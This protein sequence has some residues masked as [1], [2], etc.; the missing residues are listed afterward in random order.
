M[1]KFI[2]T[3]LIIFLYR[4]P[5]Q[6]ID[7]KILRQKKIKI[8]VISYDALGDFIIS[9]PLLE[10]IKR[11]FPLAKID[12]LCSQRNSDLASKYNWFNKL[13]P[14]QLN[15]DFFDVD[16]WKRIFAI[17][18][19]AYDLVINL[20][21]EP[22]DVAISKILVAS[23]NSRLISL[24]LRMKSKFQNRQLKLFKRFFNDRSIFTLPVDEPM[25]FLERLCQICHFWTDHV[26]IDYRYR[27]P[28]VAVDSNHVPSSIKKIYF[29]PFGS[30]NNNCLDLG[31]IRS[32]LESL[33]GYE[34]SLPA[35]KNK[36]TGE[37]LAQFH[38]TAIDFNSFLD[39]A[40]HI[41][42]CDAVVSVDTATA[43]LAVALN[44]PLFVIRANEPWR[45]NFDPQV[46]LI[47]VFKSESKKIESVN[48]LKLQIELKKFFTQI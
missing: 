46:G 26:D 45:Q 3:T 43:H 24:N 35:I 15:T 22:D 33:E 42:S 2:L 17:K 31:V 7:V 39:L 12:L 41:Q 19:Y 6:R 38:G 29:H 10:Q 23:A 34:W 5:S 40:D 25:H 44:K 4:K 1:F 32:V 9:T 16:I 8:L 14:M 27:F 37:S 20:F 11:D 21:D 13:W 18:S 47:K 28:N 48:V 36:F 30:Q